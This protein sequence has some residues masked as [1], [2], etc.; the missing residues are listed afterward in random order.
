MDNFDFHKVHRVMEF[1][2]WQWSGEVVPSVSEMRKEVRRLLLES[3]KGRDQVSSG[4][5]LATYQEWE[6]VGGVLELK[7]V[8]E[9]W[10]WDEESGMDE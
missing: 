8:I 7:F 6:K 5:F 9:E 10:D 1:M 2:N 4:G 3:M